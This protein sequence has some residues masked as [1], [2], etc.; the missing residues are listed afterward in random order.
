MKRVFL[1]LMPCLV[2]G[3][4]ISGCSPKAKYERRLKRELSSE[5]RYDSIFMGMYFGMSDKDFYTHCWKLNK[6]GLIKQGSNN[7]SVEY[8][9]GNELKYPASMNFY[10]SFVNGKIYEMPVKFVYKG[11]APWNKALSSDSLQADVLNWYEKVYGKGFIE[12][13]HPKRGLA[14]VLLNG[15]RRITIFKENDLYV[16]AIFTDMLVEKEIAGLPPGTPPDPEDFIKDL[17]N[18]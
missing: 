5:T 15:N 10:P 9:T 18:K 4:A 2:L 7:T 8:V 14:Y 11:W 16:W 6:T 12:V 1:W 13:K 3:M 17:E